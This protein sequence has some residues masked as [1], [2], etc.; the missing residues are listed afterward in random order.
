MQ[1]EHHWILEEMDLELTL[2]RD[3]SSYQE[4]RGQ[5]L[6][7][8]LFQ[9]QVGQLSKGQPQPQQKTRTETFKELSKAGDKPSVE[10]QNEKSEKRDCQSAAAPGL[11]APK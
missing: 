10:E 2:A 7:R 5:Q 3:L 9:N 4:A 1:K 6:L 8:Y 11:S